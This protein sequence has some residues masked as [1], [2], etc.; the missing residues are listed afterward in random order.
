MSFSNC[1]CIGASAIMAPRIE[2]IVSLIIIAT[3]ITHLAWAPVS[4]SCT[5]LSS[6]TNTFNRGSR[7]TPIFI[8]REIS[9]CYG[10]ILSLTFGPFYLQFS[11]RRTCFETSVTNHLPTIPTCA[12]AV[13]ITNTPSRG[14]FDRILTRGYIL[15]WRHATFRIRSSRTW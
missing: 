13:C 5:D 7:F 2:G 14:V 1:Y 9:G 15:T 4:C 6:Q 10:N 8:S 11:S 12:I 3:Y